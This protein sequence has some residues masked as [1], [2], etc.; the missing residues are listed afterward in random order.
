MISAAL[1]AEKVTLGGA[2]AS[3]HG[4]SCPSG[5]S[6][7]SVFHAIAQQN[8]YK[9]IEMVEL[10]SPHERCYVKFECCHFDILDFFAI[11]M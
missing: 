10:S 3:P 8:L 1:F 2:C 9:K 11:T 7:L 6:L 5:Y 4:I